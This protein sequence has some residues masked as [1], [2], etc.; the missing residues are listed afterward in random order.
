MIEAADEAGRKAAAESV[1]ATAK[2]ADDNVSTAARIAN[3]LKETSTARQAKSKELQKVEQQISKLQKAMDSARDRAVADAQKKLAKEQGKLG[4]RGIA[5]IDQELAEAQSIIKSSQDELDSLRAIYP[6]GMTTTEPQTVRVGNLQQ[7][8]P[9]Q[10][11]PNLQISLLEESIRSQEKR[12]ARLQAE[13]V[14][15]QKNAGVPGLQETLTRAQ[16]AFN[17][18]EALRMS[19]QEYADNVVPGLEATIK[20]IDDVIAGTVDMPQ[21]RIGGRFG[22]KPKQYAAPSSVVDKAGKRAAT[23]ERLAAE[24]KKL[25][26]KI[27]SDE[28]A[29]LLRW[30]RSARRALDMFG[31]DPDD[32]LAKVLLAAS[33]AESRFLMTSVTA[34]QERNVLRMLKEGDTVA[35]ITRAVDDGFESLERMGLPRKQMPKELADVMMNVRQMKQPEI[36]RF[37]NRFI[38]KY[39]SFFKAYATLSPG[40]HVRNAISNTIMIFA[41]GASPVN[42]ARGLGHYRSLMDAIKRGVPVETWLDDVAKR[43]SADEFKRIDVALRTMEASGGGRVQD[44]FANL[45][46]G[47][48]RVYDHPLTRASQR[49][50][51]RVEGSGHFMLGYDSAAKGLDFYASSARSRR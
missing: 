3:K 25:K 41:A 31:A 24:G 16:L 39:T 18:S 37:L 45:A 38:G 44:A 50:G 19:A 28:A 48:S 1:D 8:V 47:G 14:A 23:R 2:T 26:P 34:N 6:D 46:R 9:G 32:P 15:A 7:V 42:M 12:V 20:F 13:K 27:N 35:T 33:E 21:T 11:E 22:P 5:A 30:A 51:G 4:D 10:S 29:D 17:Q 36:A 40:F 43:V 49:I